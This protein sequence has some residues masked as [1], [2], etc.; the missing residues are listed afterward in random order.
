[1]NHPRIDVQLDVVG[2]IIL[3]RLCCDMAKGVVTLLH[4][5]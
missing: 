1:M 2:Y 4:A 5:T 3:R